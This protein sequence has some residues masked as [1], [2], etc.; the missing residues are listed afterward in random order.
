MNACRLWVDRLIVGTLPLSWAVAERMSAMSH[1]SSIG[2]NAGRS[3]NDYPYDS[4]TI[5]VIATAS[6]FFDLMTICNLANR[7]SGLPHI[8]FSAIFISQ[9]TRKT[10]TRVSHVSLVHNQSYPTQPDFALPLSST[11]EEPALEAQTRF[12]L[13]HLLSLAQQ[14]WH[15][16]GGQE[17]AIHRYRRAR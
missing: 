17:T 7:K 15:Q 16:A 11:A 3:C 2:V 13:A 14:H 6:L 10:I 1:K 4:I 8:I 5:F 9:T 12:V